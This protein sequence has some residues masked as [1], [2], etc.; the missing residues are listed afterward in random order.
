MRR[1]F[2]MNRLWNHGAAVLVAALALGCED[3]GSV[4]NERDLVTVTGVVT[5][6]DDQVPVDGGVTMTL[7][8]DDGE[9]ET[10]LFR[11][12][13]TAP[14]PPQEQLDLYQVIARVRVGDR[15]RAEGRRREDGIELEDLKILKD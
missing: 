6:K 2:P 5:M 15:V 14:P 12:L 3:P 4:E 11:S 10:L 1:Q 7:Q 9:A 13:F 8:L